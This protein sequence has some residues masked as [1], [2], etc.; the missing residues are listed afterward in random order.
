MLNDTT[1]K[2]DVHS[3][4][5]DVFKED[6]TPKGEGNQTKRLDYMG[7]VA[8]FHED[9]LR[10]KLDFM[11]GKFLHL[12]KD[13]DTPERVHDATRGAIYALEE[14][15]LWGERARAEVL[16]AQTEKQS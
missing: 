6:P 7:R 3:H 16:S 8:G 4:I 15:K 1:K 13:V 14:L 9:I 10:E 11:L 2:T 5:V 12:L